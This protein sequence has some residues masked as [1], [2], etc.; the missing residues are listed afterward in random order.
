MVQ[1]THMFPVL[2]VLEDHAL[3]KQNDKVLMGWMM[4]YMN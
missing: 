1:Q 4:A 2:T 3:A